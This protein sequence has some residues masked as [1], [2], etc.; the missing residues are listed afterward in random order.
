MESFNDSQQIVANVVQWIIDQSY[1]NIQNA[2]AILSPCE[3]LHVEMDVMR[4]DTKQIHA[5][6]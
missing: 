2:R 4:I 1:T 5:L 3:K 6:P